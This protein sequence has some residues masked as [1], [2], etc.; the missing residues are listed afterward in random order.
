MRLLAPL[1][2][3]ATYRGWIWLIMG[4]ALMMPFMLVGS[5]F[6]DWARTDPG[7]GMGG[8]VDPL[9]YLGVLPL[10]A[11]VSL[12]LPDREVERTAARRL[13]GADFEPPADDASWN[14]RWRTGCW[15][16]LHAAVGGLLSGVTLA[17]VPYAGYLVFVGVA[18]EG[19]M[20]P[21]PDD[22]SPRWGLLLGPLALVALIAVVAASTAGLR[23]LAPRLLGTGATDRL[24]RLR[25][26]SARL[27]ARNR[28]ARELHD[29]VGH[30]LSV[31]VVQSGAA[32]RLIETD[33]AFAA[34]AMGAV[35]E[36]ARGALA[37]LDTVI[38][39]LREDGDRRRGPRPDLADLESL[40]AESGVEAEVRIT[41]DLREVSGLASREAYRIVQEALTNVLRHADEP[42]AVIAVEV[43]D[44]L[45]RIA[46][47]SPSARP[48]RAGRGGRGLI[49]M[50]ERAAVLG[51][52]VEHGREDGR[53]VVRAAVPLE[54]TDGST[55]RAADGGTAAHSADR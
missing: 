17:L 35:G 24:A 37:E 28:I 25:A 19:P 50:R 16:T 30:A 1:W 12:L 2:S 34:R 8:V 18:G 31:V 36:T 51:G 13:L 26:E 9:V 15:F 42:R 44:R 6:S 53:W 38:G 3:R 45:A 7:P 22:W 27:T 11:A 41:G 33:P 40:A 21:L 54:T 39:A 46:V 32:A 43:G 14:T 4:G 49:G 23:R 55:G 10:V 5:L 48:G 29:S 52:T 20:A 47:E